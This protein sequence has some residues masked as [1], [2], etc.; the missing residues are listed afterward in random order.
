M[1]EQERAERTGRAE[2]AERAERWRDLSGEVG[3]ELA[4]WRAEHP[5][6]SWREIEEALEARWVT[7]RARLLGEAAATSPARDVKAASATP[8]AGE[9]GE[10]GEAVSCPRCGAA[11]RERGRTTRRLTTQGDQEVI[12]ERSYAQCSACGAGLFPPG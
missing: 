7:V 1:S 9:A 3:A 10:A 2:R 6:A 5:R 12:L 4:A 11:L 8:A